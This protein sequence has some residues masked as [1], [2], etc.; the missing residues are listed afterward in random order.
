MYSLHTGRLMLA[1]I[2]AWAT[3]TIAPL[4]ATLRQTGLL[5]E[6]LGAGSSPAGFTLSE[7]A[8]DALGFTGCAVQL[9]TSSAG[10][11]P[12]C[13]VRIHG[14]SSEPRWFAGRN[15]RPPR[16]PACTRL[17]EDW[18]Q[19]AHDWPAR[20]P[21]LR[22]PHCAAIHPAWAW[23]WRRVAGFARI[24]VSVE[25]VFPGEATPLPGLLADLGQLGAGPW[26]WF[27][28]QDFAL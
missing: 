19:Q 12:L 22:C 7:R 15:T 5:G 14:P 20:S 3:L 10:G 18:A 11:I 28:V 1:P 23:D 25:E 27:A 16:C 2:D 6:P 13:H 4:L 9:P 24:A 21:D 17:A 26:H 8:F